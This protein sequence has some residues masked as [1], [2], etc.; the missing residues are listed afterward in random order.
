MA[1]QEANKIAGAVLM[2]GLIAMASGFIARSLVRPVELKE[3]AFA[4]EKP[5]A[6]AAG[7]QAA[8]VPAE[9]PPIAP[10][11]ARADL[12]AGEA[13]A[14]KCAACHTFDKGGPNRVGPNLW[15][16]VGRKPGAQA[17]FAFSKPMAAV[18]ENWDYER[19]NKYLANPKTAIPGNKMAFAGIPKPEE[20]AALIA[21][22][23]SK[24]DAP[25]PMP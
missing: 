10:L 19:L 13:S 16:V 15:D 22:L 2:A 4:V 8:A 5:D 18:A 7:S 11:L 12:A 25:K 20:R 23:R 21:W 14:K 1:S 6:P 24:A 3:L 17:G 9:V